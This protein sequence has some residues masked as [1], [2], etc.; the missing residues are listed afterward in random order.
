MRRVWWVALLLAGQAQAAALIMPREGWTSWEVPAVEG[1]RNW[2]CFHWNRNEA[3]PAVCDLDNDQGGFGSSARDDTVASMRVLA[4]FTS[5]KVEKLR[6]VGP[7]CAVK[8][9]TPIRDLGRVAADD[10]AQWLA[11]EMPA[12]VSASG[13]LGNNFLASLAVHRG[14]VA[15]D[16]LGRIAKSGADVK[17]RKEALFW[18]AQA[19]G[20]EGFDMVLPFL[21]EDAE[22]K[23]REHAA[24]AITQSKARNAAPHLIRQATTDANA[25]VRSQ[26]WFWLSQSRAQETEAA[27]GAALKKES[28]RHVREQAIFALSQ[29]PAER[30]AKALA[31][32]IADASLPREDR[33][34]AIFWMGQIRSD[35]AVEYLDRLLAAK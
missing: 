6:T 15:R 16:A 29:L 21:F 19:R 11:A 26:A 9:D 5:G 14:N 27:I 33:K 34:K 7:A 2:C 20:A 12:T 4:K 31:A 18:L 24:F 28:D 30:G 13:K 3:E 1:T 25:R 17:Q 23:V 22:P 8:S 35:F 32:V 10:S